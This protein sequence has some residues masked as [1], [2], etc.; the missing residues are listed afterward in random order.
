MAHQWE[1]WSEPSIKENLLV[2]QWSWVS[3]LAGMQ[4]LCLLVEEVD[5]AKHYHNPQPTAWTQLRSFTL[6]KI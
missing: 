4:E 2:S 1:W 3:E 6:D 5:L